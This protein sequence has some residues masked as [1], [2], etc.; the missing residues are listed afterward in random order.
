MLLLISVYVVTVD[1]QNRGMLQAKEHS[2][3]ATA[4]TNH[5]S[6][7]SNHSVGW[8][9]FI[10]TSAQEPAVAE[11]N[12][13]LALP[14]GT[15]SSVTICHTLCSGSHHICVGSGQFVEM[16]WYSAAGVDR[17][18]DPDGKWGEIWYK[19][20]LVPKLTTILVVAR[21]QSTFGDRT[22]AASA[23]R[24]WNSLPPDLWQP[25]LSY[26]Q[27]RRSLKTFLFRQ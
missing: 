2:S 27:F 19:H 26:G 16:F 5:G 18:L 11:A 10:Y 13:L 22:F 12:H 25:G 23:P 6:A 1:I 24:L 9:I 7:T 8:Y 21:T 14:H 4:K 15:P 20:R 3:T 17:L